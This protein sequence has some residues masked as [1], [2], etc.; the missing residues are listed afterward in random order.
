ANGTTGQG[1]LAEEVRQERSARTAD[2]ASGHGGSGAVVLDSDRMAEL[3]CAVIDRRAAAGD[4][5][6]GDDGEG[7]GGAGDVGESAHGDTSMCGVMGMWWSDAA[8]D[9]A[10]AVSLALQR[11]GRFGA[12]CRTTIE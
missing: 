2:R 5:Q 9:Q 11:M 4:D 1:G 6:G 7:Q 3:G 12:L 10:A 8:G